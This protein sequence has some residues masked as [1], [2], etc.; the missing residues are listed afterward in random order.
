MRI[1]RPDLKHYPAHVQ[2]QLKKHLGKRESGQHKGIVTLYGKMAK[3]TGFVPGPRK[4]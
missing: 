2:Q 4:T 1:T 3:E